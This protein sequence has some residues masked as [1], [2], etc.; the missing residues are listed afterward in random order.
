MTENT[1]HVS[2]IENP[3]EGEVLV[4]LDVAGHLATVW[5][6]VQRSPVTLVK[7]CQPRPRQILHPLLSAWHIHQQLNAIT[8]T[9]V[10]IHIP[11]TSFKHRIHANV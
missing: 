7:L 5:C 1:D 3:V 4:G 10:T 11:Q 2:S 9:T 8:I 6:N